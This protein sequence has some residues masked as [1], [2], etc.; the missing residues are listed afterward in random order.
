MSRAYDSAAADRN[1]GTSMTDQA[2]VAQEVLGDLA[3]EAETLLADAL[4]LS[5]RVETALANQQRPRCF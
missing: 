2:K 4:S 3:K 5:A 1:S